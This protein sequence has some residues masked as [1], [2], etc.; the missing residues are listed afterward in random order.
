MD[1]FPIAVY[2]GRDTFLLATVGFHTGTVARGGDEPAPFSFV[3]LVPNAEPPIVTSDSLLRAVQAALR[4]P[5]FA[6]ETEFIGDVLEARTRLR[7][8][9]FISPYREEMSI[10]FYAKTGRITRGARRGLAS[11]TPY[12]IGLWA[13]PHVWV[14]RR[15]NA[16]DVEM[17]KPDE[18]QGQLYSARLEGVIRAAFSGLCTAP[19]WEDSTVMSCGLPPG[20]GDRREWRYRLNSGRWPTKP[21]ESPKNNPPA[22]PPSR[23]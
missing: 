11:P 22:K 21:T 4:L 2:G 15:P 10:L 9:P 5:P 23:P 16:S 20:L 19:Q 7:V 3:V 1:C 12:V 13:R 18:P 17:H 8:S 14:T 6:L